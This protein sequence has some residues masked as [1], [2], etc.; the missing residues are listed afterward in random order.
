MTTTLV[1]APLTPTDLR[2]L[3]DEAGVEFVDGRLVEKP[4]SIESSEVKGT[5]FA[6]LRTE[7]VKAHAARVFPSSVGF[8]CY[9]DDPA[10]FRRPD[11]SVVRTDRL[12]GID[13]QEGF[14]PIPADLAVEVVSPN[15]LASELADKVRE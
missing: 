3:A 12:A 11:V 1:A 14:V 15:D 2:R 10:N 8:R 7:A 4:V 13:P 6:L 5:V 9:P